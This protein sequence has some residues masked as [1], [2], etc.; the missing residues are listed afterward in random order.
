[1]SFKFN[2]NNLN[3]ENKYQPFLTK[4]LFQQTDHATSQIPSQG[5]LAGSR[6][7]KKGGELCYI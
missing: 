2:F 6:Q 4:P 1:M 7:E 5:D 3:I